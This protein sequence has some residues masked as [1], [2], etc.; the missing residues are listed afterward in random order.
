MCIETFDLEF[1][2]KHKL[3]LK[4]FQKIAKN[5]TKKNANLQKKLH[6]FS[7]YEVLYNW[8]KFRRLKIGDPVY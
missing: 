8:V 1:T 7:L 4:K 2:L 5:F 3:I 6:C